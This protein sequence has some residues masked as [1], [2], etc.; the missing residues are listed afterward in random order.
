MT[1]PEQP[2][3]PDEFRDLYDEILDGTYDCVDRIVLNA[4]F[5]LGRDGGACA[6]G[7]AS[8]MVRMRIWT[9]HI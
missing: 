7:G 2:L 5:P 4:R 8:C 1:A 6:T 3:F 9:P